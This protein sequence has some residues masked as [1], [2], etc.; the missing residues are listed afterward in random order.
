[1]HSSVIEAFAKEIAGTFR[2]HSLERASDVGIQTLSLDEAYSV[3]RK[4]LDGRVAAGERMVGYK[5]GCTSPAIRE[6]FGLSE[7]VCGRL[8]APQIYSD[9]E[10]LQISNYVDC[11]LEPELVLHI[12]SDLDGSN[13]ETSHLRSA[14]VAISPGIEIHNYRFWYGR[15]SSQELIASN[16]IHAAIVI[17][18]KYAFPPDLDLRQERTSLFING[19]EAATGLGIEIMGGPIESLRWL[20][21]HLR[22]SRAGLRAG[23][24]VIP[25]SAAKLVRVGAGDNAEARFTHFGSCRV[26]FEGTT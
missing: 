4:Y 13:V 25:G 22:R 21:T 1:M 14:I 26:R 12:G 16:A 3:Q 8:M 20:I 7:P 10:A 23:D 6:Q 11:A 9:G 15:P 24:T 17:G 5:V 19:V 2:N 18:K